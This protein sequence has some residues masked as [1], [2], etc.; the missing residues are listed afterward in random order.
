MRVDERPREP[1]HHDGPLVSP[2]TRY[3][4][5]C[6]VTK[7]V[8]AIRVA[9]DD[10]IADTRELFERLPDTF[11][12]AVTLTVGDFSIRL[13]QDEPMEAPR[14]TLSITT[15]GNA[16]ELV[17]TKP[18]QP[19]ETVNVPNFDQALRRIRS[20]CAGSSCAELQL[21]LDPDA[22]NSQLVSVLR[23]AGAPKAGLVL[24]LASTALPAA[25]G[26][27]Q[28]ETIQGVVR[29]HYGKFRTCYEGG[30]SRLP[31]LEGRISVRFIIDR[32]GSVP[33]MIS[34]NSDVPDPEVVRCVVSEFQHMK[35]PEPDGGIVTVV[36]PIM[37]SPG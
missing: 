11:R 23:S 12:D 8:Y 25:T 16:F 21:T 28:P 27:L 10:P 14:R 26:R 19:R 31:S 29:R 7:H 9:A 13:R 6:S 33:V 36:Y 3:L 5:P 17:D 35:F 15:R 18:E 37:L 30:L 1:L 20:L 2:L 24:A 34:E 4:F 22:K 32:D